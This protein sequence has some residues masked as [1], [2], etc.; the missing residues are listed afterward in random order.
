MDRTQLL[1]FENSLWWI[2]P[3]LALAAGLVYYLYAAKK[4]PWNRPTGFILGALRFLALLT[5]A[6]LLLNPFL[7][8]I[9]NTLENPKIT[10]LVDNS[11]SILQ[12]HD[13]T[14]I[15]EHVNEIIQT[16]E[17]Q[18]YE[19][20]LYDLS[21]PTD[22][23]F[24]SENVTNLSRSL[25]MI[26]DD[27]KGQSLSRIILFSDGINNRGF[28]PIYH[29]SLQPIVTVGYGDTI[30]PKDV[31][32]VE[33]RYNNIVYKGNQFPLEVLIS[34]KGFDNEKTTIN[35]LQNGNTLKSREIN[36]SG[37]QQVDFLLDAQ[38]EG[39]NRYRIEV[40]VLEGEEQVENNTYD[41]FLDVIE[42]KEKVL[43]VAPAPHP[44]IRAIRDALQTT[45]NYETELYIPGIKELNEGSVFD[46]VIYHNALNQNFPRVDIADNTPIWYII[47]P[48]GRLGQTGNFSGVSIAQ[49]RKQ[50]DAVGPAVNPNF[51]KFKMEDGF[52]DALKSYPSIQVPYGE[53]TV[54]GPV[55]VLLYQK[56]GSI[57]TSRPLL[58]FFDDGNT[59]SALLTGKGIWRW[60]L[61]EAAVDGEAVFFNQLVTKTIQLLSIKADKRQFRISPTRRV[62]QEG[63]RLRL[64]IETYNSIYE[65]TGGNNV[66]IVI[67]AED[68]STYSYSFTTDEDNNLFTAGVLPP[69]IY[70]YTARTRIGERSFTESGE[71]LINETQLEKLDRVANHQ[72]LKEISKNT[73]GEFYH[74]SQSNDLEDYLANLNLS[75]TIRSNQSYMPLINLKW[76]LAIIIG[77]MSV[78]WFFRKYLGAY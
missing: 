18:G 65:R 27:F 57:T 19:V 20:S 56:V 60:K 63:E 64:T 72:L 24:F 23:L 44:D 71:F 74:F 1:H 2:I 31:S 67:R 52:A 48:D 29:T 6:F 11:T 58:S 9:S 69:G 37:D 54:N 75:G 47:D 10:L 68:E 77:L 38:N 39:L 26:K 7:S 30:P 59:K 70:S 12:N 34:T 4:L 46:V 16:I 45:N 73:G 76:I 14:E 53:Y 66:D 28:S 36:L 51:S 50:L 8:L 62:Y 55:E 22:S 40:G 5:I 61:Q 13:S 33:A 21:G 43:I 17:S 49:K 35:V 42:G 25:R 78:E 3:V 15:L 41:F 32:I